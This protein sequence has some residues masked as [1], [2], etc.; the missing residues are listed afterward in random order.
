M[1]YLLI[2]VPLLMAA[3]TF[4]VPSNRWR[5]WMLPVGGLAHLLLS[6]WAI[7]GAPAGP[8]FP[9]LEAWLRLDALGKL[10]LGFLGVLFFVCSLYAPAYLALRPERDN[11]VFCANL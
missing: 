5:P 7:S 10:V 3:L 6:A 1:V 8:T 4:A 9:E 2:G 11:R